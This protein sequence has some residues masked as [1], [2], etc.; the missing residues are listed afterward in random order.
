MALQES[1][2]SLES[3]E[4]VGACELKLREYMMDGT[5]EGEKEHRYIACEWRKQ[6]EEVDKMMAVKHGL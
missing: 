4:M 3:H 2:L 1:L 5:E 6:G